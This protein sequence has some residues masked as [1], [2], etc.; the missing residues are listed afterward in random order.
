MAGHYSSAQNV[1]VFDV[2]EKIKHGPDRWN[3]R[4]SRLIREAQ[5]PRVPPNP[6]T[7]EKR[8][9]AC[10]VNPLILLLFTGAAGRNRTH[11]PLVRSQV[12]YPAELQPRRAR[13]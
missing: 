5:A 6:A 13:V 12:L 9:N 7:K 2:L 3:V 4:L 11:D 8:A 10:G 1:K